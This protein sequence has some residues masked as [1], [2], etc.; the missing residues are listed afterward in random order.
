MENGNSGGVANVRAHA[1]EHW[2]MK[3]QVQWPTGLPPAPMPL[4]NKPIPA[5]PGIGV[6][7]APSAQVALA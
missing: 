4:P 5:Q 3:S 6:P 7:S 1:M 2:D